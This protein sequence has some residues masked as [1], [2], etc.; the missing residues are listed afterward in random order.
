LGV[1]FG[2]VRGLAML[3]TVRVRTPGGLL[4]LHRAL[5]GAEPWSRR[6]A[7]LVQASAALLFASFVGAVAWLAVLGLMCCAALY[8]RR[9]SRRVHPGSPVPPVRLPAGSTTDAARW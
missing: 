8:A 4:E 6:V 2:L 5:A 1:L 9:Q 3:L 7:M